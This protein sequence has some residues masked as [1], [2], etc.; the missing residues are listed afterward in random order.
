MHSSILK[1][2]F[3]YNEPLHVSANHV[4]VIRDIKYEDYKGTLEVKNEIVKMSEQM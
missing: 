3:T 4:D 2:V 1:L